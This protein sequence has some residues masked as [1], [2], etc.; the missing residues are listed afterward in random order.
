MGEG[1]GEGAIRG[2]ATFHRRGGT[3]RPMIV[4]VLAATHL[5]G[6]ALATMADVGMGFMV[7]NARRSIP[8]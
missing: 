4:S 6:A 3:P 8:D 7:H 2:E 1:R 5:E